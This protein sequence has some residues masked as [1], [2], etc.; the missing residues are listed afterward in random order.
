MLVKIQQS[1]TN[2]NKFE[3][4]KDLLRVKEGGKEWQTN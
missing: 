3:I 4:E 2:S 1:K